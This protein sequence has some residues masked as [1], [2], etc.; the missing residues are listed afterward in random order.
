MSPDFCSDQSYDSQISDHYPPPRITKDDICAKLVATDKVAG[1]KEV[2]LLSIARPVT[3]GRNSALWVEAGTGGVIVSCQDVSANGVILNG[4]RIRRTSVILMDGDLL[5]IIPSKSNYP[6]TFRCVHLIHAPLQK[7]SP[8]DSTPTSEISSVAIGRFQVTSHTL[9]CGSFATVH[10]AIDTRAHRQVACKVLTLRNIRNKHDM[11]QIK[12][13][14]DIL[15]ALDHPNINHVFEVKK[16]GSFLY[17][18]LEICTG[19][20]LFA[21][22]TYNSDTY[23]G[24]CEAEAKYIMYQ[25]LRGL[26]YMH[27]RHVSHRGLTLTSRQPE[28]IL[29]RFPGRYPHIQIGDFGLARPQAYERTLNVV[30]TPSYLPPEGIRAMDNKELGYVG[31]PADCWSIGVILYFMLS[32]VSFI[33]SILPFIFLCW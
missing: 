20:D 2:I 13:E 24:L 16:R 8:F 15:A 7:H 28:N 1:R 32:S 19:S 5:E 14:I 26:K 30:G 31:M 29:V 4:H 22:I 12:K 25:L 17:I 9:G 23:K 11:E 10:L 21:F 33:P 3:V 18:F 27:D 6:F